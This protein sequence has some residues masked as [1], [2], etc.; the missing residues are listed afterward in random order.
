MRFRTGSILSAPMVIALMAFAVVAFLFLIDTS[1]NPDGSKENANLV[2]NRSTTN[3]NT[4]V[5]SNT[6]SV[7]E[8]T[9]LT[10]TNSD[11]GAAE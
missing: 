2:V 6:N 3:T 8:G 11:G 9:F 7:T 10:N 4:T 1:I 5:N